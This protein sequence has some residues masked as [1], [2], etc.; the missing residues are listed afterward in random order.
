M[1]STDANKLHENTEES[2]YDS[3]T[4]SSDQH[5]A[6]NTPS[7]TENTNI[8]SQ[9]DVS[10]ARTSDVVRQGQYSSDETGKSHDQVVKKDEMEES[11]SE[12]QSDEETMSGKTKAVRRKRMSSV[13]LRDL[14][15]H[16]PEMNLPWQPLRNVSQCPCGHTFSFTS[17][18]VGWY[19]MLCVACQF[20]TTEMTYF[21]CFYSITAAFVGLLCVEHVAATMLLYPTK[22]HQHHSVS[23]RPVSS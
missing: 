23:A 2:D 12:Q 13:Y 7:S 6:Q 5:F 19:P 11:Q 4:E 18:K 15:L 10:I 20:L 22:L 17:R 16:V 21:F 3:F 9:E 8:V 14:L 1:E